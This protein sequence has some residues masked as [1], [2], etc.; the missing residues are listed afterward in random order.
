MDTLVIVVSFPN[1]K[2]AKHIGTELVKK[3]LIACINILPK[4]TSIYEWQGKICEEEECLGL[5]KTSAQQWTELES[6]LRCLHPYDVP[7]II[8]LSA[9]K[10][11][12]PYQE[13]L[14]GQC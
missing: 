5:L 2:T 13:W 7:E 10:V 1:E 3:Q 6:V 4:M 9:E 11:S 14:H 12:T 8:A